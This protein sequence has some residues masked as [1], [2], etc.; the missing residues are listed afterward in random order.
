M[1]T[2]NITT[3]IVICGTL[4]G[5]PVGAQ[6]EERQKG[7]AEQ[8]IE[9][10]INGNLFG[11]QNI[12]KD[13]AK[14]VVSLISIG[15]APVSSALTKARAKNQAFKKADANA[16]AEFMKWLT[17]AVTY[18]RMDQDEIAIIQK[19]ESLGDEGMG[20][21]GETTEVTELTSEQ[22]VSVATGFVKGMVQLG[23][24][25]NDDGEAVVILGWHVDTADQT[26]M[27]RDANS[28]VKHKIKKEGDKI[29]YKNKGS[30]LS[31]DKDTSIS[32]DAQDFL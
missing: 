26:D 17:T 9:G 12:K 8:K 20:G 28:P 31:P 4:L 18:T 19:G 24:G 3:V 32:D 13:E 21:A 5:L 7:Y 10:L 2:R 11:V 30:T 22:I 25:I 16:R 23:A 14:R 29:P 27:V 6:I 1:N 15:R